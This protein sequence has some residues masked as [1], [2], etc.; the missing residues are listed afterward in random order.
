LTKI[1]ILF[2]ILIF[3]NISYAE[4]KKINITGNTRV[5]SNLIESLVDKRNINVDSN[6]IN[7]LTKKIYDTD[8]FSD[9]K[10]TYNQ[11]TLTINLIENPI[12]NFFYI[13]GAEDSELNK[14]NPIISL[15]ENNIFSASKLKKDIES[16]KE[17]YKQ[18]G[19]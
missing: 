1:F 17:L 7:N 11:D 19:Y 6:F 8:F 14:I 5:T 15:K 9:V 13:S 3:H 4:I 18:S 16:I 2:F 10:I 12:I